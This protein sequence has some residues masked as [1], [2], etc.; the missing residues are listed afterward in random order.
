[1]TTYAYVESDFVASAAKNGLCHINTPASRC[2]M[3]V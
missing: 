2:A 3:T 1:M